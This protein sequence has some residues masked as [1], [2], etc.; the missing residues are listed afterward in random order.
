MAVIHKATLMPSKLELITGYL[1]TVPGLSPFAGDALSQVGAYRFDDPAGEVGIESHVLATASGDVLHLPVVYRNE[2]RDEL[3][4]WFVGTMQHSV[5]GERWVYEAGA[6][7]IYIR[8]LARAIITGGSEV[9]EVVETPDGPVLR[10]PSVN[11]RGSGVSGA[12][13]PAIDAVSAERRGTDTVVAAGQMTITIHHVIG[14][15]ANPP[16]A[17]NATLSGNWHGLASTVRLA[18]IGE[19]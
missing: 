10:D 2:R 12:S 11:V 6:D 13:V 8:E 1:L 9:D 16:S 3:D 17:G 14:S 18:W 4:D 5:L 7:E 19:S 15:A